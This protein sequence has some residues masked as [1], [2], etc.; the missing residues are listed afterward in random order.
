MRNDSLGTRNLRENPT[1]KV[2]DG[3]DHFAKGIDALKAKMWN[4]T[5]ARNLTKLNI[6]VTGI[7]P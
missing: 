6:H 4:V 2:A 5:E 1:S 3:I 7:F